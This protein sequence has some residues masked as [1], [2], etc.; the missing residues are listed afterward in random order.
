MSK[1][2]TEFDSIQEIRATAKEAGSH[3]FDA[4]NMRFFESQIEREVY[5]GRYFISSEMSNQFVLPLDVKYGW[6]YPRLWTVREVKYDEQAGT[7]DIVSASK[8]QQ[9][10]TLDDAI[11]F[12]EGEE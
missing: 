10:K 4:S 5:D 6:K 11:E 12:A 2:L 3:W 1:Q 7:F 8:F 9:F